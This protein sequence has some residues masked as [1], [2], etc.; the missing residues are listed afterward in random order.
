MLQELRNTDESHE[1][2]W[3]ALYTRSR[4]EFKAAEQLQAIGVQN[5]LTVVVKWK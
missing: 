1:K 3:F 5:Y 4:S 2:A